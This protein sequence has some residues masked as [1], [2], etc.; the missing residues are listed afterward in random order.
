MYIKVRK[1]GA[2]IGEKDLLVDISKKAKIQQLR[3]MI[4]ERLEIPADKQRL[5]YRGKQ[6]IDDHC[7]LEYNIM[8]NDVILLMVQAESIV[9]HQQVAPITCNVENA[10]Q[11][12]E[13]LE[14]D[15]ESQYYKVGDYIDFRDVFGAWFEGIVEKII[16]KFKD[17]A[18][19]ESIFVVRRQNELG[20]DPFK[21]SLDEVRPRSRETCKVSELTEGMSVLVNYNMDEP[22]SRGYWYDATVKQVEE[23][24]IV[25]T[26]TLGGGQTPVDDCKIKIIDD[27]FKIESPVLLKDRAYDEA[28]LKNLPIRRIPYNCYRCKDV[29]GRNCKKCGCAV[30]GGKNEWNKILLCDECDLGYHIGCLHPPL[31]V[32]PSVDYWYCPDCKNDENEI[33]RAGDKLKF[34][35]KKAKMPS[36]SENATSRDWGRGMACVGKTKECTI[37]GKDHVG[38][39]PGV[40]VGTCWRYRTQAAEAGVHRLLVHGIHGRYNECAYSIVLAGGYEDDIDKG[41][42]FY[43]TGSGGRDLSGN[44]RLNVQS[45][46]QVLTKMNRALALNCKAEIDMKNGAEASDWTC[47]SR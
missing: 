14:I 4:N 3:G 33:V 24:T 45:Y 9:T 10:S 21:V 38:P 19:K 6:L 40:E 36:A 41:D 15:V 30:C 42:E 34:S 16:K 23:K 11:E 47:E 29:D 27:I 35:K 2:K 17:A 5:F 25:G 37:V 28:K 1:V 31:E 46:D 26:V 22:G 8:L 32:V 13:K 43:Y 18:E 44:K 39:V 7:I 12:E 20:R